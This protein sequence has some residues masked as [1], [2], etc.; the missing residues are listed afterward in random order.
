MWGVQVPSLLEP[1]QPARLQLALVPASL[2]APTSSPPL[3]CSAALADIGP[4]A[5]HL[6]TPNAKGAPSR[7]QLV[8]YVQLADWALRHT[9]LG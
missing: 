1:T 4:I 2:P 5:R 3:P 7:Q 6:L 8:P 9:G